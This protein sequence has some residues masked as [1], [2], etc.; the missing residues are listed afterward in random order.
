VGSNGFT[1]PNRV[2]PFIRFPLD[3]H[4]V[5]R[6]PG[7]VRQTPSNRL[8]VRRNLWTFEEDDDVLDTPF[9]R[10]SVSGK[11]APMSPRQAA[12]RMASVTA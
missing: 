10:A 6:K 2:H 12:P 7:G 9:Q 4:L 1:A 8:D 3:A 5:H 11:W